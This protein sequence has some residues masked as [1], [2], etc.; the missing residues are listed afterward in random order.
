MIRTSRIFYQQQDTRVF[1]DH[2]F[3]SSVHI[4]INDVGMMDNSIV[5]LECMWG[6]ISRFFM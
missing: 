2:L 3:G 4:I 1:F 6:E 5:P